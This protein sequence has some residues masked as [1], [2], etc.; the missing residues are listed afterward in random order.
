MTLNSINLNTTNHIAAF[1]EGQGSLYYNSLEP[2]ATDDLLYGF[3]VGKYDEMD[4]G[5]WNAYTITTSDWAKGWIK[6]LYDPFDANGV[7]LRTWFTADS[8][9]VICLRGHPVLL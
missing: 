9:T 5:W 3:M 8:Y 2:G 6:G 4:T 7:P 1:L